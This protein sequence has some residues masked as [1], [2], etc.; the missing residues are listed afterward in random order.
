MRFDWCQSPAV[1]SSIPPQI[2]FSRDTPRPHY[3]SGNN[4]KEDSTKFRFNRW[5]VLRMSELFKEISIFI[6]YRQDYYNIMIRYRYLKKIPW[7]NAVFED[8]FKKIPPPPGLHL[9][10]SRF[11]SAART[12]RA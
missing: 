3:I 11:A 12:D 1:H 6:F 5:V 10:A 4:L 7:Q 2:F 9:D 8:A